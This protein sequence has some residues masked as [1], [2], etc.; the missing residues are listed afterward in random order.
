MRTLLLALLLTGCVQTRYVTVYCVTQEQF[1]VLK[2]TQPDKIHSQ[3][4]GQAD[5][6]IL[7]ITAN[8]IRL[9]SYG[10]GLLEVLGGCVDPKAAG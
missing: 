8:S 2:R 5:R 3:L 9:R 4:T 6:D 10:D 7:T 1:A